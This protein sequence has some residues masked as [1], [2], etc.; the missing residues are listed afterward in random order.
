VAGAD[1]WAWRRGAACGSILA[2]L[3][4]RTVADVPADRSS[5]S[6][7]AWLTQR[8]AL[9][10]ICSDRHAVYAEGAGVGAPEARQVADRFRLVQT[11]WDRIEQHLSGQRYR[12]LGRAEIN[13]DGAD[14]KNVDR[15]NRWEI[16]QRQFPR[17]HEH[18]RHGWMVVDISWHLGIKRRRVDK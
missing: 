16:L 15:G 14:R 13:Q 12:P 17:V 5:A 8:P 1:E 3:E 11:L 18:L 7:A 9:E 10:I 6:Q 2:D 4:A